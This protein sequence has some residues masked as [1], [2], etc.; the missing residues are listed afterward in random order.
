MSR[1][2]G[3]DC[4][5]NSQTDCTYRLQRFQVDEQTNAFQSSVTVNES[6]SLARRLTTTFTGHPLVNSRS[7]KTHRRML[8][9]KVLLSDK[10]AASALKSTQEYPVARLCP[11]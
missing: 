2:W 8:R 9:F 5:S 11:S 7:S 1:T 10:Q 3:C 6:P 4:F